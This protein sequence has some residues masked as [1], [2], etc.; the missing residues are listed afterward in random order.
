MYCTLLL[1]SVHTAL[2]SVVFSLISILYCI[3]HY[4]VYFIKPPC[5]VLYLTVKYCT[6]CTLQYCH[7]VRI[8]LTV[9]MSPSVPLCDGE[10]SV[11]RGSLS[12]LSSTVTGSS[13][14]LRLSPDI[15]ELAGSGNIV[16]HIAGV[17]A[18]PICS[19]WVRRR[20]GSWHILQSWQNLHSC[21]TLECWVHDWQLVLT[22]WDVIWSHL[23]WG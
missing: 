17:V 7:L 5:I 4:R 18:V 15:G 11:Y 8:P 23:Y 1:C 19:H 9:L 21:H 20:G 12:S 22:L 2:C 13:G 16:D 3:V 10:L 14:R 6:Y